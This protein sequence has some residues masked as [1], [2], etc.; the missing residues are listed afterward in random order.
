MR[1]GLATVV[2]PAYNVAGYVGECVSSLLAQ[3]Y[4]DIEV[5]VVDDGSTDGTAAAVERAAAG[6]PRVR[7]FR[8]ENGGVSRS[9]NFAMGQAEGEY[10][11][12]VDAD[13]VVAPDYVEALVAPLAAGV[14]ELSAVGVETFKGEA[15]RFGKGTT[16]LYRN[17]EIFKA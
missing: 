9:R 7:L 3:T 4:A 11:L 16:Q 2:V 10:L 6:D 12:F 13:D 8:R 1:R 5:V 15:P 17:D 14:C